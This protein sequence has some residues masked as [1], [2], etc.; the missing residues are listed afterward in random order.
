MAGWHFTSGR[1]EHAT[2]IDLSHLTPIYSTQSC[3]EASKKKSLSSKRCLSLVF[4]I[5]CWSALFSRAGEFRE[6]IFHSIYDQRKKQLATLLLGVE[7]MGGFFSITTNTSRV[8]TRACI[9][10]AAPFVFVKRRAGRQ[11]ASIQQF[12][13]IARP[14]KT[15]RE[16]GSFSFCSMALILSR[17]G[18]LDGGCVVDGL[19]A[20]YSI[21]A[22]FSSRQVSR[23][24]R[25]MSNGSIK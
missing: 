18:L 22:R 7:A 4:L 12:Q 16:S 3:F 2:E 17:V 10:M 14:V 23:W 6:I 25:K 9:M 20:R 11:A 21:A 15:R 8:Y 19:A 1:L 24:S 13:C 5:V